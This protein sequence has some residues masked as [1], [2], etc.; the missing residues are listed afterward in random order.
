VIIELRLWPDR[1]RQIKHLAAGRGFGEGQPF[2]G[3]PG[4]R[5]GVARALYLVHH[6]PGQN[7]D[8]IDAK[9][10]RAQAWLAERGASTK[11]AAPV[12]L[13]RTEI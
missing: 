6:D 9:L 4:G 12:Q 13:A 10:A 3:E 1:D 11:V 2:I 5:A 7:D 8:A